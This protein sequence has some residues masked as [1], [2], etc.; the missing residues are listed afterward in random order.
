MTPEDNPADEIT[1]A[2][3]L[4]GLDEALNERAAL[5]AA[6]CPV[7]GA[8]RDEVPLCAPYCSTCGRC[9]HPSMD[10]ISLGN[11]I[12]VACLDRVELAGDAA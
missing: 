3:Y 4:A 1:E 12:C 5:T 8:F 2:E 10:I 6:R 11:A 7:C 9:A